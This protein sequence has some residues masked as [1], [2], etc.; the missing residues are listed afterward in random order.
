MSYEVST[1]HVRSS[2]L[3]LEVVTWDS[4]SLSY[5]TE[6]ARPGFV[7]TSDESILL[8]FTVV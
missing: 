6:A 4:D 1:E 2:M 8:A 5:V 3:V 7:G